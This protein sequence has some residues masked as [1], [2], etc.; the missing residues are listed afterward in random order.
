VTKLYALL[1]MKYE[2]SMRKGDG[3]LCMKLG[4]LFWLVVS[5]VTFSFSM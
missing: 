1:L 5:T 4:N 3:N 2:E